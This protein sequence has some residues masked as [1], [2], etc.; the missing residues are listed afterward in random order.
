MD[1]RAVGFGW[2]SKAK[3]EG[4]DTVPPGAGTAVVYLHVAVFGPAYCYYSTDEQYSFLSYG[5]RERLLLLLED[6]YTTIGCGP[7]MSC[8]IVY[9][10]TTYGMLSNPLP[11]GRYIFGGCKK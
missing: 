11:G 2:G 6:M 4:T 8:S 9:D 3:R 1:L 10:T 5:N 7:C